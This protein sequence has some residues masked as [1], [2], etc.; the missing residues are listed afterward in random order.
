MPFV[1]HTDADARAMLARIGANSVDELF[2]EIDP[3]LRGADF[4]A[5]PDGQSEMTMLAELSARARQDETGP[6]FLGAGC[7]D[8]HIPAAVWDIAARGEFLTAYT[9][10]QAEASQG[11]LQLIYEYQSMLAALTG[12]E[13]S[14]ASVYD[15]GSALAEAVLMAARLRR[16]GRRP[17]S[18]GGATRIAVPGACHPLYVDAAR[19]IVRNQ[20]VNVVRTGFGADG[21]ASVEALERAAA[22]GEFAA[23]VVQQPNFFGVIEPVDELVAWAEERGA[24]TI[25]VVNPVA[26]ALLKPP[27]EWNGGGVDIAC[28]DGQPLGVPMASGGPSF[29]FLCTRL[30]HVRQLPGRLV[31]RTLDRA[32]APGF[33]LTLQAREQHIRRGKATSNICTN[34]GLLVT[35]ATIHMALLGASGLRAVASACHQRA[36]EL[37][38]AL[39]AIDGVSRRFAAPFFHECVLDVGRPADAVAAALAA[40]GVVG[41]LPLGGYLPELAN[42]LLVCATEK[43]TAADI[44]TFQNALARTLGAPRPLA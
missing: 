40:D 38:A 12:L 21:A 27:G 3:R 32:G 23:V 28:G 18:E 15:G 20:N 2:D 10:Y 35:A 9:P 25:A 24:V 11:T 13:V 42:C 7:Y 19:S 22:A 16:R 43:R 34:Q 41:G 30:R 44:R 29:G 14:N 8:H 37:A 4:S 5:L 6:C 39:T 17:P 36:T 31:G 33:T 26:L 1:P